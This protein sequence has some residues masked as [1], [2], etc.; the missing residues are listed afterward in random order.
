MP[1]ETIVPRRLYRQVAEQ[2]R[3]LFDGGEFAVGD[4]LPPE[5]ELAE[6]M[7]ISRPT[8]REALIALEV[9]GR[10]RIRVG[11]GI[12]VTEP[13]RMPPNPTTDEGPFELLRAREFIERA[14]AEEAA[15]LAKPADVEAL[16]DILAR[17]EGKQHPNHTTIG[18]D[19]AFHTTIAGILG[20]AVLA[21]V[22][23]ELFDQRM[24]PFFERLSSYFEDPSTWDAALQ[25]HRLVRDAI[26]AGDAAGARAAMQEHLRKSQERFSISF[27]EPAKA[28]AVA[29]RK[30]AAPGHAI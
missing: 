27:R 4:R 24:N 2:L 5:R 21:R 25:E 19:R 3:Q 23:G 22:V 15:R 11:S 1:I 18:L 14:V 16:D 26:A 29:E 30:Q 10:V 7:G 9:E 28:R 12:Y 6:R 20:N 8:I 17:M 13:P